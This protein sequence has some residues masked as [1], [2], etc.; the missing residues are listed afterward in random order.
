MP[1]MQLI[2]EYRFD[3][4]IKNQTQA[5]VSL[6]NRG[7]EVVHSGPHEVRT[8]FSADEI[9]LVMLYRS[10]NDQAKHDAV[11]TLEEHPAE[12]QKESLA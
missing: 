9:R 8:E 1:T 12:T 4:R 11:R 6:L 10:A 7:L 3:N 2:D 5:I